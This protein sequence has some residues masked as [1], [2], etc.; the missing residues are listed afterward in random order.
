MS[1]PLTDEQTTELRDLIA[2]KLAEWAF[3]AAERKGVKLN[4]FMRHTIEHEAPERAD[5]VM[6]VVQPELDRL[7]AQ[8]AAVE[9]FCA[10]RAE[11]ITAIN[12]C[13]PENSHDYWRWQGLAEGR[14]Q[15]S[16]ELNLPVGWPTE[17]KRTAE[18]TP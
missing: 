17:Y 14:R 18:V 10:A 5:M 2:E 6:T 15:L 12:N 4:S 9:K 16:Q 11:Y 7:R 1:T 13:S 3:Q 8:V